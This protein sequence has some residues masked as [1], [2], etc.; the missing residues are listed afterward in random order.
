M[1][2]HW[3]TILILAVLVL[4]V[5]IGAVLVQNANARKEADSLQTAVLARGTLTASIGATGSIQARQQAAMTFS[6]SGR[7]G[8]VNVRMG[9]RVQAGQVLVEMD[10]AFYPQAVLAAQIDLINAQKSLDD[11]MNSQT[12]L[13][14]AEL[15]LANAKKAL[16]AAQTNY[17]TA[18]T[19]HSEGW[20]Q[21]SREA[22]DKAYKDWLV[23]RYH[24]DGS[25]AAQKELARLYQVYLNALRELET[26]QRYFDMG[27]GTGGGNKDTEM[28]LDIAKAE[29]DLAKARYADA[30][31][32]YNRLKDGVPNEDL[33][34]AQARLDAAQA[35]LDQVRITAPFAGTILNINLRP[36]D[37]V[38]PGAA[39]L[40]IADLTELHVDVPIAEVDYNRLVVGQRAELVLDAIFDTVYQGTVQEIN[41]SATTSGGSVAYP[42]KVVI[43]D[44]DHRV[45]PGMTVAVEIEIEHLDNVL[46]VPNRAVRTVDGS[47]VV[48]LYVN[49]G[50]QP[51]KIELG[52]S[53]DT[54]SQVL[55]GDLKEGDVIVLNP[56]TTFFPG[57][58]GPFGGGGGGGGG[59]F[60]G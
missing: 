60:G 23:F 51:V 4:A 17:D 39:A 50:M 13:A 59:M 31:T 27:I 2:K 37:I 14:Q 26:A 48:Y 11:L 18:V 40:V 8:K 15:E 28:A 12:A 3:R 58:G 47:R 56:P 16:D 10:P 41:L 57:S 1:K 20:L 53:N 55:T 36:G 34:A 25:M 6:I 42:V 32:A 5:G 45:L 19:N 24:N 46:L 7:V 44:P 30:Q 38:N 52:A 49:G 33:R 43:L 35:V 54:M 22:A 9:E 21:R 29:L